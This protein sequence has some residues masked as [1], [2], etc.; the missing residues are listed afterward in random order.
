MDITFPDELLQAAKAMY[1]PQLGLFTKEQ[2]VKGI[3]Y[4][5]S[6]REKGNPDFDWPN[7]DRIIGSIKEASRVRALHRTFEQPIALVGHD[8]TV[9]QEAGRRTI[10]Q[11][12]GMFVAPVG[13]PKHG[14][15]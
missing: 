12:K 2:I 3:E 11:L 6:E 5:K 15:C 10:K 4:L 8:K 7:L 14:E 13:Q 9:A 1:A